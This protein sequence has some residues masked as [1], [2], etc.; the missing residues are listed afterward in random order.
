M[1]YKSWFIKGIEFVTTDHKKRQ[2]PKGVVANLSTG[3][4]KSEALNRAAAALVKSGVFFGVAAG[5]FDQD[6]SI[7][8]PGSEPSVCVTGAIDSNDKPWYTGPGQG[9]SWGSRIDV[10]APGVMVESLKPGGGTMFMTGTSQASPHVVGIAAYL[11]SLEGLR[12]T[13][14]LCDRIKKLS[15]KNAIINQHAK[16]ANRIAFNGATLPRK[17]KERESA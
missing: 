15:T 12:G 10:F 5:N 13:K 9:T 7:Y 2:C 14:A 3:D 16:T 8:S 4:E 1:G 17:A 11:A 6:A